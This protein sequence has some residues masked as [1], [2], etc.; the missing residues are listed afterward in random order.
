MGRKESRADHPRHEESWNSVPTRAAKIQEKP[1]I[2]KLKF[3]TLDINSMSFG[4]RYWSKQ[5]LFSIFLFWSSLVEPETTGVEAAAARRCLCKILLQW[6]NQTSNKYFPSQFLHNFYIRFGALFDD[7]GDAPA[8][9]YHG[10]A[11]EPA[12][13]VNSRSNMMMMRPG[14]SGARS[15][16]STLR[17]DSRSRDGSRD[18]DQSNVI[19]EDLLRGNP[20]LDRE[21]LESKTKPLLE[22]YLSNLDLS[23][24]FT[25]ICELYH[26]TT[27]NQLV[28]NVFNIVVEKKD[29]DRVNAGKLFAHL[30][31]SETLPRKE[32]QVI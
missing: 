21:K 4:P 27:I 13:G 29:K 17:G 2:S 14:Y 5:C 18:V 16:D 26:S 25:C 9:T 7:E 11:S 31:R 20:D 6:H 15:R 8:S 3:S 22:E 24:A 23:E 10:R 32:F 30:L 12:L 28:E 1:D 19:T